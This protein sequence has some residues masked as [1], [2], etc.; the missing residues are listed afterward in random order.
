MK[1]KEVWGE[2][3]LQARFGGLGEW[4]LDTNQIAKEYEQEQKFHSWVV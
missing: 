4:Q 3:F 1:N 2:D